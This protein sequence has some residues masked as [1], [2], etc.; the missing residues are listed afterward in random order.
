M[1]VERDRQSFQKVQLASG[2]RLG[3]RQWVQV[4]VQ[5]WGP[6]VV[7]QRWQVRALVRV[8]FATEEMTSL[9]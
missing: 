4:L 9:T 1:Q 5:R 2:R 3:Q 7:G 6:F 8:R